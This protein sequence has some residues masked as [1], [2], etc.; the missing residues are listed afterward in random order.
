[1]FDLRKKTHAVENG[2]LAKSLSTCYYGSVEWN[3]YDMWISFPYTNFEAA[4]I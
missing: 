1:M 4:C 3:T 2:C